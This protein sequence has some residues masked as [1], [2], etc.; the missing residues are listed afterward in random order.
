[1]ILK[2]FF[3]IF[4]EFLF[5]QNVFLLEILILLKTGNKEENFSYLLMI[6]CRKAT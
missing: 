3:S 6:T 5:L 4:K 2:E 1:M